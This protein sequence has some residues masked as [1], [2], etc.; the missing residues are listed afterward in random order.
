MVERVIVRNSKSYLQRRL[1][2][3]VLRKCQSDIIGWWLTQEI[4]VRIGEHVERKGQ[5]F[6]ERDIPCEMLGG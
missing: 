4:V 3:V 1:L 6:A 5:G 2:E